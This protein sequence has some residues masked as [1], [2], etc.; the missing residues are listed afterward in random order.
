ML[1]TSQGT[2]AVSA[3]LLSSILP[4]K[5]IPAPLPAS[6]SL[7][8]EELHKMLKYKFLVS[9]SVQLH[10]SP[11]VHIGSTAAAVGKPMRTS[12]ASYKAQGTTFPTATLLRAQPMLCYAWAAFMK[13][14][15]SKQL[16]QDTWALNTFTETEG[17][18][19]PSF[20]QVCTKAF[21]LKWH[22]CTKKTET[23]PHNPKYDLTWTGEGM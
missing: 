22:I 16:I 17:G 7:P 4:G 13:C 1:S 18:S 14:Q 5:S 21:S 2:P 9:L 12:R 20:G 6:P 10:Q 19:L 3:Q 11:G 23:P 15:V 8:S